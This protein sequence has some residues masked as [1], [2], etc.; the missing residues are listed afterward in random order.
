MWD[1]SFHATNVNFQECDHHTTVESTIHC[2]NFWE[3][4]HRTAVEST[5]TSVGLAQA[6]PNDVTHMHKIVM[7]GIVAYGCCKVQI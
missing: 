3:R 1:Q 2:V 5:T 6:R 7:S 4:D